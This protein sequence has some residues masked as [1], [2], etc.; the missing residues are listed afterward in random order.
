MIDVLNVDIPESARDE[1]KSI[2]GLMGDQYYSHCGLLDGVRPISADNMTEA[3][4]SNLW[5]PCMTVVGMGDMPTKTESPNIIRPETT[6]RVCVRLPPTLDITHLKELIHDT[7][8]TDVP[9]GAHTE[10]SNF[11]ASPGFHSGPLSTELRTL[12]ERSAKAFMG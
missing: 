5:K 10:L 8:M 9:F 1:A 7:L 2:A 4:L 11:I 6:L 12:F 3:I